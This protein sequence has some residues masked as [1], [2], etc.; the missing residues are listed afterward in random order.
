MPKFECRCGHLFNL[1]R[2]LPD[3][4]LLVP[5]TIIANLL[6]NEQ[7]VAAEVVEVIDAASKQALA[8]PICRRIWLEN[9]DDST[10]YDEYLPIASA[11][12]R[13]HQ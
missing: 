13:N 4:F 12:R 3:D 2:P 8:C 5:N 9:A 10:R 11:Q 1:S 7:L 6:D